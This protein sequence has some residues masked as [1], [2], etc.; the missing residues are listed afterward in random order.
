MHPG[1]IVITAAIGFTVVGLI[2]YGVSIYNG[3]IAMKNNIGRSWANIDVLLK[4]RHDELPKLV[5][6]C[7]GYM[8]HE[9]GVFDKLS[10]ARSALMAARSVGERAEAEG[11]LTRAIGNMFA[12]A[13]AY[14]N[15]KADQSF[16]QLQARIS[17]IENQIADRREFYNDTVTTYN[18]RIQQVPDAIVANWLALGPAELFKVDE[19][20]RQDVEINFAAA[21]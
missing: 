7:E 21:S 9:R 4:Q 14:P 8:Q 20:D 5:K 19:A 6:T 1:E 17:Q 10:E 13:E 3:L 18:T 11:M 15:L 16:L 12:V 2:G